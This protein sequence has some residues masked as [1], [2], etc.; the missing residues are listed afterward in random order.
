MS[1]HSKRIVCTALTFVFIAF[2]GL[3]LLSVHIWTIWLIYKFS[4]S[5]WAWAFIVLP[6]IPELCFLIFTMFKISIIN[7]Y[8]IVFVLSAVFYR[9][10]K[11]ASLVFANKAD[12]LDYLLILEETNTPKDEIKQLISEYRAN[13]AKQQVR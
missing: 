10:C 12:E 5:G 3:G 11:W 7:T 4:G 6:V 8:S 2:Y 13:R 9:F 1:S